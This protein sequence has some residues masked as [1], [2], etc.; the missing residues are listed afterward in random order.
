MLKTP[1]KCL[2]STFEV[3]HD[4]A[5]GYESL[6][7]AAKRRVHGLGK[8]VAVAV[9]VE[10]DRKVVKGV[11]LVARRRRD[12]LAD[13]AA[14]GAKPSAQQEGGDKRDGIRQGQFGATAPLTTVYRHKRLFF[15]QAVGQLRCSDARGPASRV[16][17]HC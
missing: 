3:E 15:V 12:N 13:L 8:R 17:F 6:E 11:A 4:G 2:K 16:A 5:V 7:D 9:V 1:S 14:A 10:D